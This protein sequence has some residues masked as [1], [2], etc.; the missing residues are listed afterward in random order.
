M[1]RL[2]FGF[3][4]L[5]VFSACASRPKLQLENPGTPQEFDAFIGALIGQLR[6]LTTAPGDRALLDSA[7]AARPPAE[8]V[9]YAR[10]F[11]LRVANITF[12]EGCRRITFA[13]EEFG[14]LKRDHRSRT[15]VI[16][17]EWQR[18]ERRALLPRGSAV[19]LRREVWTY[20]RDDGPLT[21]VFVK[22]R[23]GNYL[24]DKVEFKNSKIEKAP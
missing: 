22:D 11:F 16:F 1:K 7:F 2:G 4:L 14:S 19:L 18:R 3:C 6:F 20:E 13:T 24:L 23:Y 21:F 8:K 10:L 17:G 12:E 5:L 15:Y 9:R